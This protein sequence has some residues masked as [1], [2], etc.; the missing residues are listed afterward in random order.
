MATLGNS[1]KA[2]QASRNSAD[3]VT[4]DSRKEVEASEDRD[5]EVATKVTDSKTK[6]RSRVLILHLDC[7][8]KQ[9]IY[10]AK[11]NYVQQHGT[12][13]YFSYKVKSTLYFL[14]DY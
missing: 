14:P 13:H 9:R 5:Q 6:A 12:G 4:G 1:G 7:N 3:K 10:V 11:K 2:I 8:L